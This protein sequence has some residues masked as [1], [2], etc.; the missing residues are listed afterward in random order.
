MSRFLPR[1]V[2]GSVLLE[3]FQA[4]TGTAFEP[5]TAANEMRL[6]DGRNDEKGYQAEISL[7]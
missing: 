3:V 6:A 7:Q 2:L 5:N 4:S 1:L